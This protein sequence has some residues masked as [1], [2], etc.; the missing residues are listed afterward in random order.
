[1]TERRKVSP[2]EAWKA[3]DAMASQQELDRI[4]GLG[5]KELDEELVAA[6]FDPAEVRTIG[7][8]AIEKAA[9]EAGIEGAGEKPTPVQAEA[10][11]GQR[12]GAQVEPLPSRPRKMRWFA[13]SATAAIA[14]AVIAA[15]S[16]PAN[17]AR[18]PTG[19][20]A[21]ET[22]VAVPATES[23][24]QQRAAQLRDEAFKACE[25]AQWGACLERLDAAKRLDPAG[26]AN[27]RVR[28]WRGTAERRMTGPP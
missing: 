16:G 6:G 8:E 21:P 5:E 14:A 19:A 26:E 9:R 13:L 12:S 18:A 24:L 2:V 20:D 27:P 4:K 3:I 7:Q 10:S 23:G 22:G 15:M 28:G 25:K 17:V 1:V 11:P